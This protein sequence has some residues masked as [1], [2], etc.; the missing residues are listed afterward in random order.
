MST[1]FEQKAALRARI[2]E[3]LK[4]M[5][6]QSRREQSAAACQ[7][8]VRLNAFQSAKTVLVYR[9]LPTECD[10]S[11]LASAALL[12]GKRVA[13]PVCGEGRSLRLYVPHDEMAFV[14]S[15]YG[16]YEPEPARSKEVPEQEIDFIVVPGLAFDRFG[17]RLGRG[18][19]YYDRLLSRTTAFKAGF[20][21]SEQLV[22][23]VPMEPFDVKMDCVAA[24]KWIYC[25]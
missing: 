17:G 5:D 11:Q 1:L 22:E 21:F 9:A 14:L 15:N 19:G 10:P 13:Y 25:E 23:S 20:A 16:I 18:A 2:H 3:A 8:L 24:S 7:N 12:C 6:E 4:Q